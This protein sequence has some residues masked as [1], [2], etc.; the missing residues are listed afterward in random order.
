MEDEDAASLTAVQSKGR[1]PLS[2]RESFESAMHPGTSGGGRNTRKVPTGLPPALAGS[3]VLET[4]REGDLSEE[5]AG[6]ESWLAIIWSIWS[7]KLI[8]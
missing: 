3:K 7:K 1:A 4:D 5:S 2:S 8:A 6:R